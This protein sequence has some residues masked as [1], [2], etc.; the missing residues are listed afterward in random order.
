MI[1]L[2]GTVIPKSQYFCET[3][4]HEKSYYCMDDRQL[5]CIYC[6]YHGEHAGHHCEQMDKAKTTVGQSLWKLKLKAAGNTCY[7]IV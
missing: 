2:I 4:H 7:Y 1:Q 6:A 3:H 5:V